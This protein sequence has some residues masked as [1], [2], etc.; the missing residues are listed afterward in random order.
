[1]A[2]TQEDLLKALR[3]NSGREQVNF[4]LGQVGLR[5]T[6]QRGGQY[7][8][9]VGEVPRTNPALQLADALKDG[10]QLLNSFVDIQLKQGEIEASVLTPAEVQQKV[11]QGD[12]NA[13][14]FLDKLGKE[15]SFTENVYKRYFTSTVQPK[16]QTLQQEL[17]SRPVHEYADMGI[18]TPEDFAG[19]A[20]GRVK[21]LTDEFNQYT[22]KSPYAQALHNQLVESV[23]PDLVQRQVSM[24]DENVTQFNKD[25]AVA[26]LIP[27][28]GEN[29]IS[30]DP[31]ATT[32]SGTQA[33]FREAP[34]GTIYG[35]EKKGDATFDTNS[36]FAI[37]ANASDKEQ[38][39]IKAGK[40]NAARLIPN[41]DFALSPDLEEQFKAQGIKMRDT[42]TLTMDDGT[43]H[44]G[45][46]MDRTAKEFQGKTLSGR[47]DIYSPKADSP[48]KD[49]KFVGFARSG[50]EAQTSF[51]T[52]V[53]NVAQ[54]NIENLVS[55]KF[56]PT[57]ASKIVR[58][59]FAKQIKIASSGGRFAEARKLQ[60]VLADL[61][62][63]GQPLFGS[64]DGQ[65][66]LAAMEDLIDQ[67]ED[68]DY[69]QN[70]RLAKKKVEQAI[71]PSSLALLNA[72]PETLEE[73]YE[74][75][76]SIINDNQT[77]T[78]SEIV[79]GLKELD[80]LYQN[81]AASE[82]TK[83][84]RS[85]NNVNKNAAEGGSAAAYQ[86][87]FSSGNTDSSIAGLVAN[88]P[89][90]IKQVAMSEDINGKPV[91]NP[92]FRKLLQDNII[93]LGAEKS[94]LNYELTE[95]IMK[96]EAFTYEV[97]GKPT[98]FAGTTNKEEQKNLHLRLGQ[99]FQK[100]LYSSLNKQLETALANEAVLRPTVTAAKTPY[101]EQFDAYVQQF[102]ESG[103][104]TQLARESATKKLTEEKEV[105]SVIGKNGEVR[106]NRNTFESPEEYVEAAKVAFTNPELKLEQA[107]KILDSAKYNNKIRIQKLLP[108]IAKN[109]IGNLDNI[110]KVT[111]S[112]KDVGI[113]WE[114]VK[115]GSIQYT[116]YETSYA[117]G[118]EAGVDTTKSEQRYYAI[119]DMIEQDGSETVFG[120]L[121]IRVLQNKETE[122]GK[123]VITQ[124]A[125]KYGKTFDELVAGQEAWYSSRNIK[126][127][128]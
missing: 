48:V 91:V 68:R 80:Q 20:N 34:R 94:K 78:P 26:N 77:L 33:V 19:Y 102:T 50:E 75:Q 65:L 100:D 28:N 124:I 30:L 127:S 128:K 69:A 38:A 119:R 103:M 54:M 106:T 25:E 53:S 112:F 109:P 24:F 73:T 84:T 95:K 11:E 62:V 63:G 59:D 52:S 47:V 88:A 110:A 114:A 86:N 18:T 121:P 116:H 72:T 8:V 125:E 5:P 71:A 93:T 57:E 98:E 76:R 51:V 15:K 99:L 3:G 117:G 111:E 122:E 12:P 9:P 90:S 2:T 105:D 14:S 6:I 81:K 66:Q 96:G 41:K 79:S 39:E 67:D 60:G 31:P 120:I 43:T 22:S 108:A 49:K 16:L 13:V 29:G 40:N 58:D 82:Y 64:T 113:P 55:N 107:V 70:E 32:Q 87:F 92:A 21:E 42:V 4:D 61:K 17:K 56:S 123:K 1:M 45:R 101:Q 37:G 126:I 74:K 89:E 83:S 27:V 46:W 7:N 118:G 115:Q 104:S 35:F 44:T 85:D 97:D 36:S 23:V 10:S